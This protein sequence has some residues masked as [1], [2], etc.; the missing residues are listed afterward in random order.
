MRRLAKRRG[1][2]RL[3]VVIGK[4]AVPR[5]VD[6]NR[7][8]RIVRESFRQHWQVQLPSVDMTVTRIKPFSDE[9]AVKA[10]FTRLFAAAKQ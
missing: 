8:R 6:R 3:G 1:P 4:R 5:A 10:E 7:L 9:S 2:A